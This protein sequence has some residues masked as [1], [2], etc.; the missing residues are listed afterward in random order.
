MWPDRVLNP[1]SLALE[2]DT[3]YL[4]KTSE[5]EFQVFSQKYIKC[6]KKKKKKNKNMA[7]FIYIIKFKKIICL[8]YISL[9]FEK[10]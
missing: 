3:A 10:A 9:K 1:G 6:Q 7:N 2:S 4:I 5:N 8:N